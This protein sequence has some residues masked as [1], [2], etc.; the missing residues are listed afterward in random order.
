MDAAIDLAGRPVSASS[1]T[2]MAAH[3]CPE[4]GDLV[5]HCAERSLAVKPYFAHPPDP[6][7]SCSQRIDAYARESLEHARAKSLLAEALRQNEYLVYVE[8]THDHSGAHRK[9]DLTVHSRLSDQW[10]AVEVQHS[11]IGAMEV[12]DRNADHRLLGALGTIWMWIRAPAFHADGIMKLPEAMYNEWRRTGVVAHLFGRDV[13]ET[14]DGFVEQVAPRLLSFSAHSTR[15]YDE[16]DQ[17]VHEHTQLSQPYAVVEFIPATAKIV[18]C[19]DRKG[20]PTARLAAARH[21]PGGRIFAETA[22]SA[23]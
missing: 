3:T 12:N 13:I 22:A 15:S 6:F 4:C 9:P 20:L 18:T 11:A 16:G 10:V 14:P 1:A 5:I 8:E 7:A 17:R 21:G 19:S 23:F 2:P